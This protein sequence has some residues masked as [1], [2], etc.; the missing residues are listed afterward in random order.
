MRR[1]RPKR[2]AAACCE[3]GCPPD[4]ASN[5]TRP[6][7]ISMSSVP[8]AA[9]ATGSATEPRQMF[10]SWIGT[11]RRGPVDASRPPVRLS[12]ARSRPLA[13]CNWRRDTAFAGR[14]PGWSVGDSR[15]TDARIIAQWRDRFQCHV[16][17]P[18][19]RPLI[20][21]FAY[22][23]PRDAECVGKSEPPAVSPI[24]DETQNTDRQPS[25]VDGKPPS[26]GTQSD[27][28]PKA[29]EK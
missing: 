22:W 25:V 11:A 29:V 8:T 20:F 10:G 21:L 2:A 12:Q 14:S 4:S 1:I 28:T 3:I 27:E 24:N 5:S 6:D 17:G 9:N 18:L 23:R 26:V 15:Q 16:A 19:D 7:D 13:W